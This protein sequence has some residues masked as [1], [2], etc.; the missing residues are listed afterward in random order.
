MGPL[1]RDELVLDTARV[2]RLVDATFPQYAGLPL[3]PLGDT[4]STNALFRL[5]DDLLVRLPRQP[6]GGESVAKEARWLPFVDARTTT[7]V[8]SIVGVGDPGPDHPERWAVTR[9][10]EGVRPRD[11][12]GSAALARDLARF[13]TELRAMEVPAG[14]ADDEELRWYRGGPLAAQ[15]AE[16]RESVTQCRRLGLPLDLDEALRVWD[17]ALEASATTRATA[18]W[19]HGDLLAENLL[20]DEDGHL[21]AVLD[22]GTLG[23]GDPAVDLVVAWE[24]LGA[25]GRRELRARLDV[26][27]ATWTV[28]RGW[29]LLIALVTFPYYGATMPRRC[30]DRLTMARAALGPDD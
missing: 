3:A 1:H 28:S 13:L 11:G 6:G 8:P 22:F 9:W 4:G 12:H 21:S 20:V 17:L 16:L 5:G 29:A 26:D 30:A 23:I 15:D 14:A 27:D 18:G 10:L 2:R 19:Y 24:V 7:A 25:E